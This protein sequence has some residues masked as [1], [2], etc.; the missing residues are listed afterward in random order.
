MKDIKEL[1]KQNSYSEQKSG[2]RHRQAGGGSCQ[3]VYRLPSHHPGDPHLA[4]ADD[5]VATRT[6]DSL[7]A[8]YFDPLS[9]GEYL[10]VMMNNYSRFS[11]VEVV[12]STAADVSI[13]ASYRTFAL[14]GGLLT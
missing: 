10:L 14:M 2:S 3:I 12:S 9:S 13:R 8:D 11:V 6:V 5:R 7:S 1:S 4:T